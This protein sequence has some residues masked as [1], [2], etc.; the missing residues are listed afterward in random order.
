MCSLQTELPQNATRAA[1][2]F[3]RQSAF[4]ANDRHYKNPYFIARF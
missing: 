2:K 1:Q 4:A 3:H